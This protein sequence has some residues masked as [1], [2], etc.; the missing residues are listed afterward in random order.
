MTVH[1]DGSVDVIIGTVSTGQGHETSFAQLVTEWLGVP[2]EKV[3]ILT[4]DTQFVKFGGAGPTRGG[5]CA[6]RAS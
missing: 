6:W 4:G 3:R 5:A 2:F 1:P